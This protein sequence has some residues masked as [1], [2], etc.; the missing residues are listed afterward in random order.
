MLP[1]MA[2]RWATR[3][4]S[5]VSCTDAD[6]RIENPVV[7]VAITSLWSP[8]ML[9]AWVAIERAPTW[10][11]AGTMFPAILNILG[12]ISISPWE[13]VN[14]VARAP[15]AKAPWQAPAAPSSLSSSSTR[16]GT[17]R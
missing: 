7:R 2:A 12:S 6:A 3:A 17:P 9:S 10:N 16:I 8:K 4:R 5:I 14:V 13:F 11:T 1:S 15:A